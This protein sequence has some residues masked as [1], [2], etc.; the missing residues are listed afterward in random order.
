[1]AKAVLFDLDG[2]LVD[3]L[4]DIS[5]A[6]N[7]AL[8]M[9]GLPEW[10][11]EEYKYLVGDGAKTLAVRAVRDR[12]EMAETVR[13]EYQKWYEKH[14]I[15]ESAA[16]QG[17]PETLRKLAE[18]GVRL[19]VLSNKPDADTV[20]VVRHFYPDVPFEIIRGQ[21]PGVPV[22]PDP[23]GAIAMAGEMG[24]E[25]AEFLYLGDT[26]VDMN[27]ARNAGM[28]P[29]GALWGFRTAEELTENG[30][31]RLLKEPKELIEII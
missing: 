2:T 25:P 18:K 20:R 19:C 16:Y 26:K 30:A 29:I 12:Q 22:K 17:M 7:R 24:I 13:A 3:T 31:K 27:C 21:I 5:A 4:T 8:R 14:D 1:M 10:D 23:T 9:H 28:T 11:R 15:E 6:M